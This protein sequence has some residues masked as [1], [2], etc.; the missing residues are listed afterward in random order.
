ML[1]SFHLHVFYISNLILQLFKISLKNISFSLEK[2]EEQVKSVGS[3]NFLGFSLSPFSI[4]YYMYMKGFV[5]K[6]VIST[7]LIFQKSS[8]FKLR[9]MHLTFAQSDLF[10]SYSLGRRAK[11]SNYLKCITKVVIRNRAK[12]WFLWQNALYPKWWKLSKWCKKY[13]YQVWSKYGKTFTSM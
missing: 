4:S 7:K 11:I 2:P 12:V 13:T 8:F 3:V 5:T 6:R 10:S 1:I 9:R